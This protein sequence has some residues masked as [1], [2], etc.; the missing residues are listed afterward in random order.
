MGV[1][2]GAMLTIQFARQYIR[3]DR[4]SLITGAFNDVMYPCLRAPLAANDDIATQWLI[5]YKAS[6]CM[7]TVFLQIIIAK[8]LRCDV[9]DVYFVAQ[10]DEDAETWGVARGVPFILS[11]PDVWRLRRA[12][13]I[14]RSCFTQK[15]WRFRHLDL[16]ISGPSKGARQSK[17]VRLVVTDESHLEKHFE[18]G[19]LKEFDDRRQSAGWMGRSVHASTAASEGREI[20]KL[21]YAGRQNEYHWRC[22][23][24]QSLIWPL[25]R[26]ITP[27]QKH[28]LEYYG[29]H[30]FIWEELE[31]EDATLDSIRAQCPHCD[32]IFHDTFQ[33]RHNL[34]GEDYVAMNP[35][36]AKSI[37][38]FRWNVFAMSGISWR[39]V[40]KTYREAIKSAKLGNLAELENFVKKQLCGTWRATL[41]DFGEGK[42]VGDYDVGESWVIDGETCKILTADYQAGKG[43]EG[44]HLWALRTVW[45]RNGDSRRLGYVRVET[46]AQLEALQIEHGIESKNVYVDS[47]HE[48]RLVFRECSKRGW[49]AVRGSD[50]REILHTITVD[51]AGRKLPHPVNFP[52]PYS[53]AQP[54]SGI[55]GDAQ[56][57]RLRGMRGG[58]LQL[59]SG[60]AWCI[61]MCNPTLYGYLSALIGGNSGRYFGIARNFPAEYVANMPAF[62]QVEEMNDKTNTAKRVV[63]K[64]V[65]TDHAWDCEVMALVGAIRAKFFPL[66]RNTEVPK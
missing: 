1:D 30:I 49:Y 9:G 33:E 22:P 41:P 42:G 13:L 66:A 51:D 2:N 24:C 64:R 8:H 65:R 16:Y 58:K 14:E 6:G 44:A 62:L 61:V 40:L 36:A 29:K 60:W 38:S 10:T 18:D 37:N 25:W 12:S 23:N 20:D 5:I 4:A 35:N 26:E 45:N 19:A 17:Q 28:A 57:N 54:Q 56:P 32:T 55:V 48:N 63:W 43:D 11:I 59:G 31:S 50:D 3:F 52:M 15:L 7:G 21:F 46:F 27:T 53:Q 47:G 34:L 39:S